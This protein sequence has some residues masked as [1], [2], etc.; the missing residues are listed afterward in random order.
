M[1]AISPAGAIGLMQI[2]PATAR[3]M[4]KKLGLKFSK[5]KLKSDSKYNVRLG[6]AYLNKLIEMYEGS[7]LLAFAAYNAGPRKVNEWVKLYGDPRDPLISVVDWV[8]HIPYKETR[9]YVMRV[10]ESLHIYRIRIN[11]VALP[12]SLTKDLKKS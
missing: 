2:L 3:Q 1:N 6:S 11:G 7:Y 5:K 10:A 4:S 8:E 12:V 9:N